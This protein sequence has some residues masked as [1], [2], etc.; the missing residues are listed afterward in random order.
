M[1]D[2]S[3][4]ILRQA[5]EAGQLYGSVSTRDIAEA[6][7]A[8]GFT[9]DR[10]QVQLDTPIKSRGIYKTRV[11]LH[12]EV[13]VTVNVNVAPTQDAA[14]AQPRGARAPAET[15][16]GS[17]EPAEAAA[18]AA[19]AAAEATAH[20]PPPKRPSP[21]QLIQAPK[22]TRKRTGEELEY[23][24]PAYSATRIAGCG[25]FNKVRARPLIY[26]R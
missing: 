6:V 4:V 10:R 2:V 21:A 26:P 16:G 5:G 17:G 3:V 14:E 25:I 9:V 12:P 18:E 1:P 20:R 23:A 7:T 19:A 15:P 22:K 8:A 13:F 11:A 24:C